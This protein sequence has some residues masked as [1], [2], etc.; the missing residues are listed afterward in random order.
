MVC[1]EKVRINVNRY[2]TFFIESFDCFAY[3]YAANSLGI[4]IVCL[5]I[6]S[7][8]NPFSL[9]IFRGNCQIQRRNHQFCIWSF[10][11][12]DYHCTWCHHIYLD[13]NVLHRSLALITI[14]THKYRQ[15]NMSLSISQ[16]LVLQGEFATGM[17]KNGMK[18]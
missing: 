18:N 4:V 3:C 16:S 9:V 1:K 8:A 13:L 5:Q 12:V 17:Q 10:R 7:L 15:F 2:V 14:S 11:D 6:I